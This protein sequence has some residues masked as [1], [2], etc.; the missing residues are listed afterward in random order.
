MQSIYQLINFCLL[1]Y[2]FKMFYQM[3]FSKCQQTAPAS[4][5][6]LVSDAMELFK[7]VNCMLVN[8]NQAGY[9]CNIRICLSF[10]WLLCPQSD[11]F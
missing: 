7:A 10:K 11:G 5:I 4:T 8:I 6:F 1:R 3:L 2:F 9:C